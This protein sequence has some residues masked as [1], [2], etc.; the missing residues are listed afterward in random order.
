[1]EI[2]SLMYDGISQHSSEDSQEEWKKKYG[3]CCCDCH[4]LWEFDDTPTQV[5]I[6][7]HTIGKTICQEC[8]KNY[9]REQDIWNA[10]KMSERLKGDE[11]NASILAIKSELALANLRLAVQNAIA[12]L[13]ATKGI[14]K[15]RRFAQ[16]RKD[17]EAAINPPTQKDD[18][19]DEE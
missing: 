17:L 10:A 16:I 2:A 1:M 4:K 8:A 12:N 18:Y 19:S 3:H 13:A 11:K 6:K 15:S 5:W 7:G 9:I 14:S